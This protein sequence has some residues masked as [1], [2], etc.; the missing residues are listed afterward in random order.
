M[1]ELVEHEFVE[2]ICVISN[3]HFYS[4]FQQWHECYEKKMKIR[5]LNDGT[6]TNESRLGAS[7]PNCAYFPLTINI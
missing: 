1:D 2:Q 3:D 6:K 4:Q 7:T 5:L